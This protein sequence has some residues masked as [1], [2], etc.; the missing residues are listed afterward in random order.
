MPISTKVYKDG[1]P[2]SSS[3][4]RIII[5][6]CHSCKD[7]ITVLPSFYILKSQLQRQFWKPQ[8]GWEISSGEKAPD[9]HRRWEF[10]FTWRFLFQPVIPNSHLRAKFR[11]PSQV[12]NR[13]S[14][15]RILSWMGRNWFGLFVI[16][17]RFLKIKHL[18]TSELWCDVSFLMEVFQTNRAEESLLKA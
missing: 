16:N 11:S 18:D 9:S 12:W 15:I 13:R 8:S 7:R 3:P 10:S 5:M 6:S 14:R 2:G 17:H 4:W 1:N